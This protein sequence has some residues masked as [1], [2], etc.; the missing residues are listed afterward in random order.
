MRTL[1]RSSTLLTS[2]KPVQLQLLAPVDPLDQD[3]DNQVCRCWRRCCWQGTL[4]PPSRAIPVNH[5]PADLSP[6]ILHHEQIPERVRSDCEFA[7]AFLR[8]S[9]QAT[10][11]SRQVFDNYAVTVM[12]GDDPY[13]L[14]LFD[15]AGASGNDPVIFCTA[16]STTAMI[17]P[18]GL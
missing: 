7:R 16:S 15:T 9:V 17:R 6:D 2:C 4:L 11:A 1:D 3:A 10:R 8:I 12:I 14:G 5:P 18:G 13:T